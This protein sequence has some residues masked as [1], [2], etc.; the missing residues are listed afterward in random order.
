MRI[1]MLVLNDMT[2]DAR[3]TR[4]ARTLVSAGHEVDVLALCAGGQ[5]ELESADGFAIRRAAEFTRAPLSRPL[6]KLRERRER[7]R[8]LGEALMALA[9]DVVHCHDT[10]TLEVGAAAASALGVPYIYDAHEL[11]P[12]SLMQRRFQRSWPVQQH[13]RSLERRLV[14]RAA[15]VITVCTGLADVL[16]R[17]YG[18]SATVVANCPD[19]ATIGSREVLRARLGIPAGQAIVL[20]QGGLQPG[21]AID[22]LV[23]AIARTPRATLVVQG[24]GEYE[25]AMRSRVAALGIG[26]RVIFM[27]AVPYND[28]FALTC[29]ADIGTVCLDGVT[30]NHQLAWPNRVFMYFM[31]GVPVLGTDLQGLRELVRPPETGV[32]VPPRDSAAIADALGALIEDAPARARMGALG[33]ALAEGEYNWNTQS[34]RLLEVYDGLAG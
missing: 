12:D 13:L 14:P 5:P 34:R 6:A 20:Y 1:A 21:R 27:G 8:A 9:P 18:V 32:L 30:L 3:V 22:E 11:Y 7:D 2:A 19:L 33:R 16:R 4:E 15:A 31:A 23:E 26:D 24:R 28:L 25:P 29:G 17:R 10:N